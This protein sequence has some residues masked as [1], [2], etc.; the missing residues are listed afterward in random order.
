MDAHDKRETEAMTE[1]GAAAGEPDAERDATAAPEPEPD[2]PG[3]A[4]GVETAREADASEREA[5]AGEVDESEGLP[6]GESNDS[7]GATLES[8]LADAER[9]ARDNL[10]RALRAQAELE[11]VRRRLERDLEKAHK[12]AIE[13]FV[14]ELLPVKDSLELGLDAAGA[15]SATA[16]SIA[17][18]VELTLR[19]FEQALDK[20]GVTTVDPAGEAFDPAFHQAMTMRESDSADS[21]TVLT[22]VQKGYVLNE[23]LVRPAM[24]IV[25]K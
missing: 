19:M 11:N 5:G 13:R 17:E 20:F 23:R 9:A 16:T 2:S 10:E 25:A 21:G 12:F 22:V 6:T 24:V 14:T 8:E 3:A 18:G 15:E 1:G 4:N 7:P